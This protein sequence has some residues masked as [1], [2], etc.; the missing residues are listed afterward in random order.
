MSKHRPRVPFQPPAIRY[1]LEE[2]YG[3][4]EPIGPPTCPCCQGPHYLVDCEGPE[5]EVYACLRRLAA[6]QA[7]DFGEDGGLVSNETSCG[8]T[9]WLIFTDSRG[10]EYVHD[11]NGTILRVDNLPDDLY[12][13]AQRRTSDVN[14]LTA[15]SKLCD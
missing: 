10:R 5:D 6:K 9:A 13:L 12:E 1:V 2:D 3:D 8:Y 14:K 4:D 7:K 11:E 15:T